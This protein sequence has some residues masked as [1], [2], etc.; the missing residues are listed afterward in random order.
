MIVTER[1]MKILTGKRERALKALEDKNR[2]NK[3]GLFMLRED[4][5]TTLLKWLKELLNEKKG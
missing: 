3:D 2:I 4:E 1:A 5:A